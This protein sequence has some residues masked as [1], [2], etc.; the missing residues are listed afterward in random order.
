M[1][2][3]GFQ[4]VYKWNTSG[5]LANTT[6]YTTPQTTSTWNTSA[7]T[8][9]SRQTSSVIVRATSTTFLT[10]KNVQYTSWSTSTTFQTSQSES[11]ST[12]RSTSRS[13]YYWGS[14]N[15]TKSRSTSRTT[16]RTTSR[17]T[18]RSTSNSVTQST[19]YSANTAYTTSYSVGTFY[20][21][22]RF[23]SGGYGGGGGGFRCLVEGT[24]V[25]KPDGTQVPVENLTSGDSVMSVHG[26]FNTHDVHELH[27]F[28]ETAIT[29]FI[30]EDTFVTLNESYVKT[31]IHNFN[32][33]RLLTT[34]EH[35]HI[36]KRDGV[37]RIRPSYVLKVGDIFIDNNGGEEMINSIEV[38]DGDYTVYHL[39]TE[40]GDVYFANGILTHNQ[41]HQHDYN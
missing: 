11:R 10:L 21:T 31:D 3:I 6:I 16:S 24:L 1:R 9:K 26:N 17:S 32:N 34:K 40:P 25:M 30:K 19:S 18:S 15:T 38:M 33:G 20:Q 35:Y 37:W 7:S 5:G 36:F 12:T 41:L 2:N 39:D 28:N 13:T 27:H 29:P 4:K 8:I 22:S 23:T 14:R